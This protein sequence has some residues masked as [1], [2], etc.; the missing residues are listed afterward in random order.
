MGGRRLR[1]CAGFPLGGEGERAREAASGARVSARLRRGAACQRRP[2]LFAGVK[3]LRA[4]GDA[5]VSSLAPRLLSA[6]CTA[7]SELRQFAAMCFKSFCLTSV[8]CELVISVVVLQSAQ[9]LVPW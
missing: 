4:A 3:R 1:R 5:A 6:G 2:F 9:A 8:D 7:S